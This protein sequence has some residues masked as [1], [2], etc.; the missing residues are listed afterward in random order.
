MSKTATNIMKRFGRAL[1]IAAK[2]SSA[3]VS[4][5]LKLAPSTNPDVVKFYQTG[6]GLYHAKFEEILFYVTLLYILRFKYKCLS[7]SYIRLH[8]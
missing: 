4:E 8:H 6:K 2:V 7:I 1:V 5:I 3:A